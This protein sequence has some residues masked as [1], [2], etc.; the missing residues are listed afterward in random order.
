MC[1]DGE[2]LSAIF[3]GELEE[4][5]NRELFLHVEGCRRCSQI[6]LEYESL[7][8]KLADLPEPAMGRYGNE[9]IENLKDRYVAK[10]QVPFWYR[11]LK[12]PLPLAAA[13]TAL[14]IV[15]S[16]GFV[17]SLQVSR[18][19]ITPGGVTETHLAGF[20][21]EAIENIVRYLD[22]QESDTQETI[23]LPVSTRLRINGEPTL[24][25]AVEYRGRD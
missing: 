7:R 21:L 10:G 5:Q 12:I 1:P 2:V 15:M 17:V 22:S 16:I 14:L 19:S 25:R 18:E 9:G 3:D 13:A 11:T 24:I 4:E 8:T 23:S 6:M 20:D